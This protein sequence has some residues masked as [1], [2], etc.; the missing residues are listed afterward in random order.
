MLS[1][2]DIITFLS[3]LRLFGSSSAQ[4]PRLGRS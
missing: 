4:Q 3:T 1:R 2:E